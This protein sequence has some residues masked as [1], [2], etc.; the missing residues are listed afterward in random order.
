MSQIEGVALVTGAARQRGIGRAIALALAA[1]GADVAVHGSPRPPESYPE[2]ERE[3]GWRGA[4]SV[5][6]EITA[7]GRRAVALEA[8][9]T[10]PAAPAELVAQT[11]E[12]LGPPGILVNNAGTAGTTGTD[13]LVDLDEETWSRILAVNLDAVFR[14]CKAAVPVMLENGGGSIVNVS[15]GAG[16]KP[17][18]RFGSYSASKA[19]LNALTAQMALEFAPTIRVN[20]V[21]P[22]STETDML[23]ATFARR[24]AL[25]GAPPGTWRQQNIERIPLGRQ[26]QPA[27][28]AA[29]VVFLA[30]AGAAFVTGQ[31]LSV[32]GGQDLL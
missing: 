32:D 14:L 10:D 22:G 7:G 23:D 29:P 8:D 28:I 26:G 9:L 20:C 25:A 11:V 19:G 18:A 5:A 31:T 15:A 4:A 24:D 1:A 21:S 2:H 6:E 3:V 16:S 13:T 27:E 12:A 30:S 17:R